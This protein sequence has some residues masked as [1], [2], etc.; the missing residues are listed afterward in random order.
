[1]PKNIIAIDVDTS[2][3]EYLTKEGFGRIP[4]DNELSFMDGY[5]ARR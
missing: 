2:D 1:M 3:V 5:L 4:N